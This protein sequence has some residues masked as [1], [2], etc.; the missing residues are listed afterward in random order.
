MSQIPETG[1]GPDLHSLPVEVTPTSI[2][3]SQIPETGLG[4]LR[5]S[6]VFEAVLLL[7]SE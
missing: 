2:G 3:M 1:L 7:E 5:L 6:A 4:P